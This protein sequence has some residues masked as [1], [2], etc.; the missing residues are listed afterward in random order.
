[1][2]EDDRASTKRALAAMFTPL[3]RMMIDAGISL[4]DGVELL[5][6]ALLESASQAHPE[7]SASHLSLIT[8]VHRKDI[9]RLEHDDPMPTRSTSAARVLALWQSESDFMEKGQPRPLKRDGDTGFD[10]LV[11]RAKIDAAPATMLSVLLESGNIIET[12]GIIQ[13]VSATVVP[14]DRDEKLKVAVAT[15]K[16]HLDTTVGNVLGDRSQWD[17][18]LRYSHL[19]EDAAK[20]L[21]KQASELFLEMLPRTGAPSQ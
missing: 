8:G 1:M 13:F 12:D 7:A 17:Q 21:E 3:A 18:A 20:K 10:A 19:S 6:V 5:K 4:P 11:A 16:P 15:L 14:E 2:S 9:K